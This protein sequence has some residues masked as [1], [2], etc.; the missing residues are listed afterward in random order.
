[1]FGWGTGKYFSF[2]YCS[3]YKKFKNCISWLTMQKTE[4]AES[5]TDPEKRW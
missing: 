2:S 5:K 4:M 1:M 3:Y